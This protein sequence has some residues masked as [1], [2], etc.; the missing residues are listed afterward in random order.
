MRNFLNNL[1]AQLEN[2]LGDGCRTSQSGC[3]NGLLCK[4]FF[5]NGM[6][7]S[8]A[9]HTWAK[10]FWSWQL[11]RYCR[12]FVLDHW[13]CELDLSENIQKSIKDRWFHSRSIPNDP[14]IL[15]RCVPVL[16]VGK[17]G[18]NCG[19]S[20]IDTSVTA[21]LHHDSATKALCLRCHIKHLWT[22][23][24]IINKKYHKEFMDTLE[25][26]IIRRNHK[27]IIN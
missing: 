27:L 5:R 1:L 6:K 7:S 22:T 10:F 8:F 17:S 20:V 24:F 23:I 19:D 4:V 2:H 21:R 18:E 9:V 26:D 25:T 13:Q 11:A 15:L 14:Q 12:N 16:S 3:G